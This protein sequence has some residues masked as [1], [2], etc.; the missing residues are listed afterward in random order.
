M[1]GYGKHSR[2]KVLAIEEIMA[3]ARYMKDY[4]LPHGWN[5][6]VVDFRW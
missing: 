5:Y 6:I 2:R 4:L 1:L 3:N